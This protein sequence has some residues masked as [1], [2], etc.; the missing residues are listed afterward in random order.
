[1]IPKLQHSDAVVRKYGRARSIAN[2]T[3]PIVV[4]ATIYFDREFCRRT[5]EVQCIASEW[6]LMAKLVSRKISVP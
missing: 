1:M 5:I 3:Q 2:S 4:A 6:M